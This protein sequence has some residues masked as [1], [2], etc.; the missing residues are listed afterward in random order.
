MKKPSHQ[1]IKIGGSIL[2]QSVSYSQVADVILSS[3][4]FPLVIVVSA[5]AGVTDQLIQTAK[6][7]GIYNNEYIDEILA[8]GEIISTKIMSLTFKSRKVDAIGITPLDD[9]WPIVT[10]S[11]FGDAM[12]ILDLCT[13]NL[14]RLFH[15]TA[16]FDIVVLSGFL[17][18][19]LEGKI[20]TLGR[21]GSDTTAVLIGHCM[22]WPVHLMKT[23]A[24]FKAFREEIANKF[25][26]PMTIKELKKLLVYYPGFICEKAL[27]YIEPKDNVKISTLAEAFNGVRIHF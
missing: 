11:N 8:S 5:M 18:L 23:A 21:G 25:K 1:V 2:T 17:G 10:N 24:T 9:G 3:K 7:S 22:N 6:S 19:D 27:R 4:D 15:K 13:Q 20:T 26:N 12:P 16:K 14:K